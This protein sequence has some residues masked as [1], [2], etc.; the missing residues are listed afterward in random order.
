[1]PDG[2]RR[3]PV[4]S[5][6]GEDDAPER[7]PWPWS[8]IGGVAIVIAWLTMAALVNAVLARTVLAGGA[9]G[10][11]PAVA[12]VAANVSAFALASFAGGYLVG[13]FGGTAKVREAG[14][15]GLY[16]AAV[17]CAMA[18]GQRAPGADAG[19]LGWVL[20]VI[21]VAALGA[22]GAAAGGRLGLRKR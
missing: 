12:L 16:A 18:I 13:R 2:K 8:L 22:G 20:V 10:A 5:S 15:A 11:L 21:V 1:M 3:L 6:K 17:G 19:V 14:V 4:L 9:T 7:P